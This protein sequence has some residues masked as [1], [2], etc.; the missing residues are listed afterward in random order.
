MCKPSV[1]SVEEKQSCCKRT[2]LARPVGILLMIVVCSW[3][4]PINVSAQFALSEDFSGSAGT[5]LNSLGWNQNCSSGPDLLLSSGGLVYPG[6][7]GSGIG[8]AVQILNSG[9]SNGYS[10][11][12]NL[13]PS[14]TPMYVGFLINVTSAPGSYFD[15]GGCSPGTPVILAFGGGGGNS[16]DNGLFVQDA[17]GGSYRVGLH[18]DCCG[19]STSSTLLAY[20]VTYLLIMRQSFSFIDL[21]INPPLGFPE[22]GGAMSVSIS[23]SSTN[24]LHIS[25]RAQADLQLDG[26]RASQNWNDI[27]FTSPTT[28]ASNISFPVIATTNSINLNWTN[29]NGNG[30][31][32]VARQGSPVTG[33]PVNNQ[34]YT[35]NNFFGSGSDLGGGSYVV[36]NGSCCGTTVFSLVPGTTYHFSIFEFNQNGSTILYNIN[37]ATGNPASSSTLA[38]EPGVQA[39]N[40]TFTSVLETSMTV[41]W[42]NGNGAQRLV[43]ARSGSSISG[44]PQD[45]TGYT[46]NS[47][48]LAAPDIGTGDK[49]VYTGSASSVT[50]TGLSVGSQYTFQVF[51]FNGTSTTANYHTFTSSNNPMSR[52]TLAAEP[53]N[54]PTAIFFTNNNTTSQDVNFTAAVGLPSGYLA[55]RRDGSSPTDLPVDGTHYT[56]GNMIGAS[57]VVAV[58]PA[59]VFPSNG[60]VPGLIYFYD[61]FS[62]NQTGT[63]SINYRTVSP[64]EGSLGTLFTE[65]TTQASSLSF[66]SLATTSLTLNW[67][68]GSGTNRL[69]IARQGAAIA[70]DPTDGVSYSAN[71][72][73]GSGTAIGSGFVVYSGSGSSVTVTALTVA[74]SY[75]FRIYEFNGTGLQANYNISFST[76]NPGNRFTLDLEPTAHPASFTAVS[77]G[78]SQINLTFS[79]ASSITNADG[80]IILRRQDGANP[81]VTGVNDGMVPASLPLTAGTTLVTTIASTA[82]TS[83]NN[84]GLASGLNYNYAIIPYNFNGTSNET[85]NYR[86]AATVQTAASFTSAVEPGNQPTAISFSAPASNGFTVSFTAAVGSPAGYLA[87]RRIGASPTGAPAD[88]N[89]YA[90]NDPIGDGVVAFVGGAT[91][92]IES[93]LAASTVYH[94]DI[95]SFNGAGTLSNYLTTSPLEGS[96]TTLATEP[97]AQPTAL[98]FSAWTTTSFNASFTAAAGSP[99]GYLVLRRQ[100]ASPTGSP[101]DGTTYVVGNTIGDGTVVAVGA[102]TS[103]AE[104]S[105]VAGTTYHYD[106]FSFNGSGLSINYRTTTPLENN[107]ITRPLPPTANAGSAFTTTSFTASWSSVSG[108]MNYRLDVSTDGFVSTIPGFGNLTVAGTSQSVTGLTAGTTYQ[109]RVRASNASGASVDSNTITNPTLCLAPVANAAS[110][111]SSAGFDAS[112]N[113]VGGATSYS[114][115]VSTNSGFSSFVGIYNGFVVTQTSVAVTG[116][117]PST[118]YFYQVRANNSSGPS[119]SSSPAVN[120]T[121]LAPGPVANAAT[122]VS[123]SGFTANW[124]AAAGADNYT[125]EVRNLGVIVQTFSNVTSTSQAVSGL[126]AGTVYDYSV[127]SNNIAGTSSPSNVISVTTVPP[128]PLTIAASSVTQTSF[129]ANWNAA[130][131]ATSYLVSVSSDNFASVMPTFT[132]IEVTGTSMAVAGLTPGTIYYY[133]VKGKNSSGTSGD[134]NTSSQITV[135][136]IPTGLEVTQITGSS[137]LAS[138]S[139][140]SG[141]DGYELD[142]SR[143]NFVSFVTVY[144]A[145]PVVGG[146]DEFV[147]GLLS[148]TIYRFR[149]RAYNDGG[150]SPNSAS[151]PVLTA[152]G[153]DVPPS[154]TVATPAN[155]ST[156]VTANVT[157]GAGTKTI[158]FLHRRITEVDFT[159]E[160]SQTVGG[161][162]ADFNVESSFFDEQGMEYYFLL[163]DE[164]DREAASTRAFI[165]ISK[166][167]ENIP[168]LSSGGKIENYRI[169]SIPLQLENKSIET[170]F[171]SVIIQ[172]GGY[173]K[174]K[175]RLVQ[176]KDGKNVDFRSGLNDIEQGK[177]YWFNSV[178]PVNLSIS[179]TAVPANQAKP[180]VMTLT[181]GWNQIGNPYNFPISWSDVLAQNNNPAGV[182]GLYT[183]NPSSVSF[184][185][186]VAVLQP[187]EGGFVLAD[188]AINLNIPVTV[189][190]TAGRKGNHEIENGKLDKPEWFLPIVVTQGIAQ[191]DL[192]GIGMHPEAGQSKDRFDA[193]SLPRFVNYLELNS[194]HDDYFINKFTRDVV[195]T[196]SSHNWDLIVESNFEGPETAITWD[197]EAL[198]VN[199]AK[200]LLVDLA[201]NHIIDMKQHSSYR[202]ASSSSRPFRILFGI[203][204]H[205][206]SPTMTT[207]GRA[208]PN[209]SAAE[210]TIPFLSDG[211]RYINIS[212]F[213]LMGKRVRSITNEN[214]PMGYNEVVWDGADEQ[215]GRV[216]QGVYLYQL[217]AIGMPVQ[218]GRMVIR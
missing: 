73:F 214:L 206:L 148:N 107:T 82:T 58:G 145:Y 49:V 56:V 200:L 205:H 127:R 2:G 54:Q 185:K 97:T 192:G 75:H 182:S 179:G 183:Y 136:S 204:E 42:N 161:S 197:N 93:S 68:S 151:K 80:Y 74:T 164:L 213:D 59:N 60:L 170:I 48:F 32:L 36:D 152:G 122:N 181:A 3:L 147:T 17:G 123:Q 88:G 22:P 51:E 215:G 26:I 28:Q 78:S 194:Y 119:A 94:Y 153:T 111:I 130:A 199:P 160:P 65:P 87:I 9:A 35:A 72:A 211:S 8:N 189:K 115:D 112:W 20:G 184:N 86:T 202:F 81:T 7:L 158:T 190:R 144:Q 129:T 41:N 38:S 90:V 39:S 55:L 23:G 198:G 125:L 43:L 5:S 178:D 14:G 142:V 174:S 187:W 66:T 57:T 101:T 141:A 156:T 201:D 186:D 70:T 134:S 121:T 114:L 71:A 207:L 24:D 4:F 132:N 69:I 30:R 124:S 159:T 137:F 13:S 113:A 116:L 12:K 110:N 167:S 79:A 108:A 146:N 53:T 172:Y 47:N 10:Y 165:Y 100:G 140:V 135:P 191:N 103:F 162:A 46:G 216:A 44:S 89:S 37:T 63:G 157:G 177:G 210:V 109:Y 188:Q 18:S 92:F 91:S 163:K 106:I 76:G 126:N 21:Y 45:G 203:D 208:W 117:S 173:V 196:H 155:S 180:F 150:V 193:H 131:G 143:D 1:E 120:L 138:W 218:F 104:S 139:A 61:I 67:T 175:W 52:Y 83:F 85:Y 40:I 62:Y 25:N 16:N 118:Q 99:A 212:V 11:S 96:R 105:L 133:R 98:V 154:V 209:P 195:P 29:G 6:Y 95:F 169:F 27:V 19:N 50:V 31:I 171:N 77:A 149:V 176:Y 33:F 217:S 84:T 168:K 102:T 64:L 34:F 166:S 15:G 128:N